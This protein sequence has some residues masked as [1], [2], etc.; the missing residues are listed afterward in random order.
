MRVKLQCLPPLPALK[1]WYAVEGEKI[2]DLKKSLVKNVPGLGPTGTGLQVLLDDF[3]L[4]DW[5]STRDLLRDGDLLVL[6]CSEKASASSTTTQTATTTKPAAG[7]KRKRSPS[8]SSSSS[9]SSDDSSDS[10]DDTSDSDDDSDSDDTSSSDSS[11]DSDS[12]DDAPLVQSSKKPA[13]QPPAKKPPVATKPPAVTPP[14]QGKT[15]SRER[16]RRRRAQRLRQLQGGG[17]VA[18]APP[19]KALSTTNGTPLGRPSTANVANA[20]A[21]SMW[22][23]MDLDAPLEDYDAPVVDTKAPMAGAP[24][25]SELTMFSLRNKNKSK[26]FRKNLKMQVPAGPKRIVFADEAGAGQVQSGAATSKAQ[27]GAA[28]SQAQNGAATSKAQAEL[29]GDGAAASKCGTTSSKAQAPRH[30][31]RLPRL[32]PPSERTDLPPNVFV[33]SVDVE[34]GWEADTSGYKYDTSAYEQTY[35]EENQDEANIQLSYNDDY[36]DAA[37]SLNAT[38]NASAQPSPYPALAQSLASATASQPVASLAQLE[39]G[40]HVGWTSLEL[41]AATMTPE[42]T[43]V[44]AKVVAVDDD[45]ESGDNTKQT[46]TVKRIP[47]PLEGEAHELLLNVAGE[48][49]EGEEQEEETFTLKEAVDAGWR[50]IL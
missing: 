19:P 4:L 48:G 43:V 30:Q 23:E 34:A 31:A 3:E 21:G 24:D 25:Y 16:N 50:V 17:D 33:T 47:K 5:Q 18:M 26:N 2:E 35:A 6:K 9:D 49:G 44:I 28:A 29:Y 12:S 11:S 41:N 8:T 27:G 20:L 42:V 10:S 40:K 13:R 36:D 46:V 38:T 45:G 15:T 37:P 39:V 7:K 1:F 32:V 14:G 22:S